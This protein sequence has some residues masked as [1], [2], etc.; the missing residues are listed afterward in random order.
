MQVHVNINYIPILWGWRG[1][2]IVLCEEALLLAEEMERVLLLVWVHDEVG[3]EKGDTLFYDM[4]NNMHLTRSSGP[5]LM[6]RY[7]A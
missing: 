3:G 6:W 1:H 7:R 4:I 2:G 5:Y